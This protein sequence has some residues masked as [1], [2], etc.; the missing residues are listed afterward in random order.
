M[1][2]WSEAG[3]NRN[4]LKRLRK[5]L[6]SAG[7]IDK[8]SLSGLTDERRPVLAGGVAVLSAVFKSLDIDQMNVSDLA[9]REGLLYEL[10]G[11][12][13]LE[14]IRDHTVAALVKR[15]GMDERQGRRVTTT[16]LELLDDVAEG[17]E[18]GELEHAEL[19]GWAA[20]LHE[21]GLIVSHGSF[22]K[23]GA[24]ILANADLPGFTR[25][26]QAVIAA[27]V[28]AH[29][30]KFAESAFA[31]LPGPVA[32]ATKRLAIL[33]RIS[34][35]MHR[36]RGGSHK[37]PIQITAH[38]NDIRVS[39][40]DQWLAEHPL[41]EAEIAREAEFLAASGFTLQYA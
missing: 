34:A 33:L 12:I 15:F 16:A 17:W 18:L 6:I 37:P 23:H 8:V 1:A 41:T 22:H 28:H 39:F 35:L 7:H 13:Q 9:L 21:I 38:D 10:V 29:R 4:G 24:Y 11:L 40:P 30:R 5:A 19:L 20:R 26:Q 14:D 25:Q 31:T 3:I 27:L 36:G 2:G 32:E